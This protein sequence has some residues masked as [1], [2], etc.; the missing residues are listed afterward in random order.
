CARRLWY[1]GGFAYW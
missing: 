1:H